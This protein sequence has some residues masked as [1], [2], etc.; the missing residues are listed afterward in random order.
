VAVV[1]VVAQ[2]ASLTTPAF[3]RTSVA[4]EVLVAGLV[5]AV[6][7]AQAREMPRQ[8]SGAALAQA[9]RVHLASFS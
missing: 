4:L 8:L 3:R 2:A 9:A 6:V 7:V 1:G 5:A